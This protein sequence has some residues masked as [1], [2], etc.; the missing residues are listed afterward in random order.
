MPVGVCLLALPVLVV[1]SLL[2][3]V[4]T[5]DDPDRKEC[6]YSANRPP[7]PPFCAWHLGPALWACLCCIADLL[8][9]FLALD[10]RH[11]S[12]VSWFPLG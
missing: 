4:R 5:K 7:Q 1:I 2:W 12:P 10:K 11:I 3:R 6:D 9:A 8:F